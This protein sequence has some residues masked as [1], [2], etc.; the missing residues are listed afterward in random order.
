MSD[1]T[2]SPHKKQ[3]DLLTWRYD[4][5]TDNWRGFLANHAETTLAVVGVDRSSGLWRMN[6]AF[7]PDDECGCVDYPESE[8]AKTAAERN[9]AEWIQTNARFLRA[10]TEDDRPFSYSPLDFDTLRDVNV[11]RCTRVFHPVDSWTASDWACAMAG[12]A[13][14]A[15]NVVKKIKRFETGG[16]TDKD[17]ATV[18]DCVSLLAKELADTVIYCD[19]LAARLRINLGEAIRSK[20]NAVSDR[21]GCSLRL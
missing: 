11:L 16:N 2:N 12:E 1:T 18:E 6:S 19:L 10:A 21:E 9:L 8:D 5:E 17:P 14:E 13:G 15:C 4:P 7:S 3:F 20:F